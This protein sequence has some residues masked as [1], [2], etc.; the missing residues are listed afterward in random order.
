M[1]KLEQRTRDLTDSLIIQILLVTNQMRPQIDQIFTST[2]QEQERTR[3]QRPAQGTNAALCPDPSGDFNNPIIVSNQTEQVQSIL[4]RVL[5]SEQPSNV[6]LAPNREDMSIER[7]IEIQLGQAGIDAKFTRALINIINEQRKRLAHPEDIDPI[8]YIG[9]KN[10]LETS[11]GWIMV[12]DSFNEGYTIN[13]DLVSKA[14]SL[15]LLKCGPSL[16]RLISSSSEFGRST[17]VANGSS[18]AS[19]QQV[20][21]LKPSFLDELGNLSQSLWQRAAT[22]RRK[23]LLKRS[24]VKVFSFN[25]RRRTTSLRVWHSI[26]VAAST[27]GTSKNLNTCYASIGPSMRH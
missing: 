26:E 15:T 14:L 25:Q 19:S 5:H 9:G 13:L 4:E 22:P 1:N 24:L 3:N 18:I 21:K 7:E 27:I 17:I 20:F 16:P 2:R 23:L 8:S 11:K 12:V 6:G 10:G